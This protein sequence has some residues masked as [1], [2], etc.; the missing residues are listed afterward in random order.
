MKLDELEPG[1][2]YMFEAGEAYSGLTEEGARLMFLRAEKNPPGIKGMDRY[3]FL[4]TDGKIIP[5]YS[6]YLSGLV[7]SNKTTM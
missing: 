3:W 6:V 7:P 2:L 5:I 1:K 4:D